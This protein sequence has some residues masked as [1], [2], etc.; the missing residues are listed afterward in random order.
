MKRTCIVL[1]IAFCAA[2]SAQVRYEDILKGPGE[3][4]LTYAGGYSGQRH[5]SLTQITTANA[6]SLVPKWVYHIPKANALRTNPTVYD[7][8]M[9]VTSSNELHALDARTGRLIW[10]YRDSLAKKQATNRGAA[11]L[12]DKVFFV[13]SDVH[14]VA[15]DRRTGAVAWHKKYGNIEDG[16]TSTLAPLVVKD[17]VI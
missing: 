14:L 11:I 6:G 12:G 2:A 7:G 17:K 16:I 13:A 15:L 5:S 3:N 10:R 9:Y 8:V 1:A 4:W